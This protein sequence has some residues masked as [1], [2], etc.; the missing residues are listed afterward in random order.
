VIILRTG[1]QGD[2]SWSSSVKRYSVIFQQPKVQDI[3]PVKY[4]IKYIILNMST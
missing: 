2:G 3:S 4:R 1:G